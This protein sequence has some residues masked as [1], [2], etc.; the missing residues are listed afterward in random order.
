MK[1]LLFNLKAVQ[2]GTV[3]SSI[4]VLGINIST[5]TLAFSTGPEIDHIKDVK[6]F[7]N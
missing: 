2:T 5:L 1:N 6:N 7:K 4:N 3:K